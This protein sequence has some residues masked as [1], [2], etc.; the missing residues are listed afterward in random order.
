MS[1]QKDNSTLRLKA[2]LRRSALACCPDPVILESH[3]GMGRI[4]TEV[5]EPAKCLRGVVIEKNPAKVDILARQRPTWSVYEGDC[6]KA[7]AGGAGS[8]LRFNY[9]DLDPYGSPFDVMEAV[10]TP[11]RPLADEIQLVVNDGL[12]QMV[13]R[14]GAHRVD[15][16]QGIVRE[17]GND[18]YPVYLQVAK[19]K[20][21]R[22]TSKLGYELS[23]WFGYH[24]TADMTHYWA[25]LTRPTAPAAKAAA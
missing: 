6:E 17:F 25:T 16:L 20:V 5:Y 14:G 23:H 7:L 1:K 11:E 10:F 15:C 21:K 24:V 18:L 3:G 8:H 22:I 2:K 13:K 19:E 9:I 4:F 12:R